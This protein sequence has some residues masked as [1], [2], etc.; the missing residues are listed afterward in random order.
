MAKALS[1]KTKRGRPKRERAKY[2]E[3]A[4]A[5]RERIRKGI[6]NR[7]TLVPPMRSL[8]TE[9]GVGFT[10]IRQAID[11][12]KAEHWIVATGRRRLTISG[13]GGAGITP[14]RTI[15]EVLPNILARLQRSSYFVRMQRGIESGV[16]RQ[17]APLMI[18]H[19][20]HFRKALPLAFLE[21]PLRGI[22]V[23][24]SIKPSLIEQ[25]AKLNTP[26]VLADQ[27][28]AGFDLHSV[29][30]DN[31]T[32]GY[33]A[34]RRLIQAGHRRIAFLRNLLSSYRDVDPDSRERQQG[35]ARAIQEAGLRLSRENIF[36]VLSD[37]DGA[38]GIRRMLE[39]RPPYTAVMA[40]SSGLGKSVA[41][42]AA[43]LGIQVPR[44]LSIAGVGELDGK[45]M[46]ISSMRA[47]FYDLGRRASMLIKEPRHPAQ[48]IRV[49]T[50]WVEG[51]SIRS[52]RVKV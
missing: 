28:G 24:G 52:I 36:S 26:I 7:G 12:L 37:S 38:P 3:I 16:S 22:I 21:N 40:A 4:D 5:L 13:P 43:P 25:Y 46:E 23:V 10:V 8:A 20:D 39:T 18:V 1:Q 49:K 32:A 48:H 35:A 33:E 11:V 15:L 44:D 2:F 27:S 6:W 19:D 9:M 51:N 30:V 17:A 47:D 14:D 29:S 34:T 41:N 45:Q 31:E 50:R 42:M